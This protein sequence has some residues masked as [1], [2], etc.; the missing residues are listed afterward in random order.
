MKILFILTIIT[1]VT[2]SCSQKSKTFV[3]Q[4]NNTNQIIAY[5]GELQNRN[6]GKFYFKGT[7]NLFTGIE[8]LHYADGTIKQQLPLTNGVAQGTRMRWHSNGVM[9]S[10]GNYSNGMNRLLENM[11]F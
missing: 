7:T 10:I 1:T 2:T 5:N 4:V 11:E 6:N 8:I 9:E 3:E